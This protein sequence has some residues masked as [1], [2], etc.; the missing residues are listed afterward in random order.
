MP[1]SQPYVIISYFA[2]RLKPTYIARLKSHVFP[3]RARSSANPSCRPIIAIISLNQ[4]CAES[5][6]A[7]APRKRKAQSKR[8]QTSA[9]HRARA[10]AAAPTSRSPAFRFFFRQARAAARKAHKV[11]RRMIAAGARAWKNEERAE[12]ERDWRYLCACDPG[13]HSLLYK[14]ELRA[15]AVVYDVLYTPGG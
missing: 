13:F 2:C 12:L 10:R 1:P 4:I 11:N 14:D 6:R 5:A 8:N 3:H 15:R 9:Y 7:R